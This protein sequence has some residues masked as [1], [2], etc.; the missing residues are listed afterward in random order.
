[1][2]HSYNILITGS[3]GFIGS[4]FINNYHTI[5]DID[6]FSLLNDSIHDIIFNNTDVVLHCAA[7]VHQKKE[8]SSHKYE[9]INTKYPFDLA[10]EAKKNGVKQFVFISTIAVFGDKI[11]K[12]DEKSKFRP[13]TPYGKSKLDAEKQLLKLKD[14]N[15]MVSI[16]RPPMVYGKEAPGNI[17]FL[18]KLVRWVPIIPLGEINNKRSFVYIENL[19]HL[20]NQVIIQEKSGIFFASDDKA[21]ST[22][23]LIKLIANSMG[24]KTYIFKSFLFESLLKVFIPSFH[25]RLFMSLEVDSRITKESLSLI[26]PVSIEDGIRRMV[27]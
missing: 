11:E 18:K 26:N 17:A 12:I 16:I 20:L 5:H 15:F 8:H 24:K 3:S 7:L 22:S 2:S 4:S 14:K 21:I 23:N 9:E 10:K 25:R 19:C 6:T 1:M 13:V 27:S